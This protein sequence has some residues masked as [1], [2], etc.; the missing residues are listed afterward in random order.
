MNQFPDITPSHS[1]FP[2]AQ[3][4]KDHYRGVVQVRVMGNLIWNEYLPRAYSKED[5]FKDAVNFI[6]ERMNGL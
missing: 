2:M 5:A 4:N 6:K 3:W 1:M